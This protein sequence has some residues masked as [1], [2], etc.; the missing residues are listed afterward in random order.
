MLTLMID[1]APP[2]AD[3]LLPHL[4]RRCGTPTQ[5]ACW[6]NAHGL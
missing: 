1:I 6:G 4:R 3:D 2:A 5:E